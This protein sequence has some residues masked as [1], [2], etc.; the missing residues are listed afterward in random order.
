MAS[1]WRC[2]PFD[3]AA[4]PGAAFSAQHLVAGQSGGRFDLQDHPPV[5]YFAC[6]PV[7]ALA[8]LLA[9]FRG[10]PLGFGHLRRSG[11]PLALVEITTAPSLDARIADCN[12]HRVLASL[13]LSPATLAHHD[14]R[15]TQEVARA[16]Y[17]ADFAGLAWW[18]ALTGAWRSTILFEDRVRPGEL[19]YGVPRVVA[20]ADGVVADAR[21]FLMM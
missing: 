11:H 19:T 13:A 4:A 6:S 17:R 5:R 8:E 9:P 3:A 7:H 10:Q 16:L 18:S 21:K 15:V 1:L 14:R 2:F 12:D 20:F